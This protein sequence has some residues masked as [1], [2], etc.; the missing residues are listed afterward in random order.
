MLR[1]TIGRVLAAVP[2]IF[3]VPL[4]VFLLI[5]LVPGDPARILAGENAT[6]GHIEAVRISSGLDQPVL[7]RSPLVMNT[8]NVPWAAQ[9]PQDLRWVAE[10]K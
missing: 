6:A 10:S 3:A 5:E 9:G 7:V 1:F 4:V 2:L 8:D